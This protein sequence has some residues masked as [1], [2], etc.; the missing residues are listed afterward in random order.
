M[1]MTH[2]VI[3]GAGIGG[4]KAA[5]ELARRGAERITLIAPTSECYYHAAFYSVA[6]GRDPRDLALPLKELFRDYPAVKIVKD[7][8]RKINPKTKSVRGKTRYYKYD[9]LILATGWARQLYGTNGRANYSYGATL[10]ESMQ[11]IQAAFHQIVTSDRASG[12]HIAI[13]GGGGVGV[14]LAGALAEYGERLI[15][16]HQLKHSALQISLIESKRRL[17]P[18]AS[19]T[20]SRLIRQ[21]L[22]RQGVRVVTSQLAAARTG[23]SVVIQGRHELVDMVIYAS[24]GRNT[25][26]I[27]S[28]P[29]LFR[30]S[31]RGRVIVNQYLQA[32]PSIFIIG[33]AAETPGSGA[34]AAALGHGKFIA[35]HLIR[36]EKNRPLRPRPKERRRIVSV[37]VG[38]FWAYIEWRGLHLTGM[39]GSVVRRLVELTHYAQ[40]LSLGKA[41]KTWRRYR[42]SIERC[43]LC[44][45]RNEK[46][47]KS[48]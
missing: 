8:I 28:H 48:C 3:V 46:E 16:A 13:I 34:V 15:A 36:L 14:E 9:H 22:T 11:H 31:R 43:A 47:I 35:Q 21:R 32:Y 23:Y 17:L 4:V 10:L 39:P 38:R 19:R 40:L 37:P 30:L 1:S 27:T 44:R 42:R 6:V 41:Y 29:E 5:L 2:T 24:G 20:A 33:D 45:K 25:S 7:H 26:L 18:R 12:A